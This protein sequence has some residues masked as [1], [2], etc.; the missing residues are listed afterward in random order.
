MKFKFGLII[1]IVLS[2]STSCSQKIE[3]LELDPLSFSLI[4]KYVLNGAPTE[5]NVVFF[6]PGKSC[7]VCIEEII[8]YVNNFKSG[9]YSLTA[10]S[11]GTEVKQNLN[12]NLNYIEVNQLELERHGF[13]LSD[14]EI[15]IFINDNLVYKNIVHAQEFENINQKMKSLND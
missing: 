12:K 14:S 2:L 15:Y 8:D 4:D 1:T 9:K 5:Y 13:K 7:I 3:A 11:N 6:I 10:I